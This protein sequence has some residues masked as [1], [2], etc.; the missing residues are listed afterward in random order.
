MKK[1]D[2]VS[3]KELVIIWRS[4]HW[5]KLRDI[6]ITMY[7][8]FDDAWSTYEKDGLYYAEY[9]N[10]AEL[11]KESGFDGD[12]EGLAGLKERLAEFTEDEAIVEYG[13][14]NCADTQYYHAAEF[15]KAQA[16]HEAAGNDTSSCLIIQAEKWET[17]EDFAMRIFSMTRGSYPADPEPDMFDIAH[18]LDIDDWDFEEE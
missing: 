3:G 6:H 10:K 2:K 18:A 8:D 17:Y 9:A 5:A 4:A 11:I 1:N 16:L 13:Y 15:T 14:G 7:Y 12:E